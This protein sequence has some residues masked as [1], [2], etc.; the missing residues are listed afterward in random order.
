MSK[1]DIFYRAINDLTHLKSSSLQKQEIKKFKKYF[2]KVFLKTYFLSFI[3]SNSETFKEFKIKFYNYKDFFFLFRDIFV[4]QEYLFRTQNKPPLILD[5][6][7][8][9]GLATIY[10]KW[11][12]PDSEI[13][14]FEPD[15]DTFN[16][17]KKNIELNNY[18][19]VY[20]YNAAVSD[21]NGTLDFY[22]DKSRPGS[23]V[24]STI[25]DRLPKDKIE[26]DSISLSDFINGK[27]NGR[28]V[29]LLK[30][31]IE[32]AE[33]TVLNKI[34]QCN[35]LNRFNEVILEYHHNIGNEDSKLGNLLAEFEK[36]GFKYQIEAEN[37]NLYQKNQFQDLL[38][39]FYKK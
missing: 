30:M 1:M 12:Y 19:N 33:H 21:F 6:G 26:V 7:A 2:R 16:L 38:I 22:I 5:C 27:L 10:F 11:L 28:T 13:H 23:L 25:Y 35:Q 14:A 32:G 39:Y 8:N 29:D 9:I 20:L 37:L 31:D 15:L 34:I 4:R 17:L 3:A 36:S 18:Q 24:M